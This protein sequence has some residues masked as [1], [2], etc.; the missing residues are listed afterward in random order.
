MSSWI[1]GFYTAYCGNSC[2]C[3]YIQGVSKKSSEYK[4]ASKLDICKSTDTNIRCAS[5]SILFSYVQFC[6]QGRNSKCLIFKWLAHKNF[7]RKMIFLHCQ[8]IWNVV[9]N[10]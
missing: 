10:L 3:I 2:D 4:I 5:Q 1:S 6:K 9:I 7:K 8:Q